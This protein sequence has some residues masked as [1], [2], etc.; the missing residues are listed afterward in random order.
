M[1][2]ACPAPATERLELLLGGKWRRLRASL[3]PDSLRLSPGDESLQNGWRDVSRA[4]GNADGS[5]GGHL[6]RHHDH[7]QPV[8]HQECKQRQ[9]DHSHDEPDPLE[10]NQH[11]N[12]NHL[13]EHFEQDGTTQ[14][15]VQGTPVPSSTDPARL[16]RVVKQEAGGLGI[17][18]RG[19]RENNMPVVISRI[20]P[21][22][23]AQRCGALF[24]GDA[25]VAV[26]GVDM[27][28][29]S[30]D[31]AVKA[32]RKA[33]REVH[34]QV[35][36]MKEMTAYMKKNHAL[37]D[38]EWDSPN[39]GPGQT[40]ADG[41]GSPIYTP[42]TTVHQSSGSATQEQ[43]V[44]QLKMCYVARNLTM[45]DPEN[46]LIELHSPSAKHCLVLRARDTV[47]ASS[48]FNALRSTTATLSSVA[49]HEANA[50][51]AG[52]SV[53][54]GRPLAHLTWSAEQVTG[55][56]GRP[57]WQPT[58]MVLTESDL[59]LYHKFPLSLEAWETPY[60]SYPLLVT[61]LVDSGSS[62][63][64]P[65]PGAELCF[66]LRHGGPHGAESHTFRA[67]TTRDLSVWTRTLLHSCYAAVELSHEA[68]VACL[69]N[70]LDCW[71]TI[72]YEHGFTV[73]RQ[74]TANNPSIM[75]SDLLFTYPYERLRRSSDDGVSKLYLNFGGPEGEICLDLLGSPKPIVFILH[76]FLS[77]KLIRMGLVA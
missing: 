70:D 12:R 47:A 9:H 54:A 76:S 36:F 72:H 16:V 39:S 65:Q 44:I 69:W 61:R 46:R 71:L 19:G 11:S 56:F 75:N 43:R 27:R 60:C 35:V 18:I 21:G 59:Y 23:A 31:E 7:P 64:S 37:A 4:N 5:T 24:V 50:T 25:I 42:P 10:Q 53:F 74:I 22:L 77:A 40:L 15:E 1:H 58:L 32:L 62:R 8:Q 28:S 49:L 17:S 63:C 68:T 3:G 67:E 26:D 6:E 73:H 57:T 66:V 30:H 20:F 41:P 2:M 34:L 14:G 52:S 48:W 51:C 13:P 45:V 38:I 29:A 55:E 33:G